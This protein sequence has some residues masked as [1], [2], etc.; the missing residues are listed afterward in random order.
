MNRLINSALNV[1]NK[2]QVVSVDGKEVTIDRGGDTIT[3]GDVDNVTLYVGSQAE[4]ALQAMLEG[5]GYELISVGE[6][7]GTAGIMEAV[8]AGFEA[9]PAL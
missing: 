3:L 8:A 5:K 1:F 7:Q 2:A 4:N 9:S 6:C